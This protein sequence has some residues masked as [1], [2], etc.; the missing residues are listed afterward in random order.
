VFT[1]RVCQPF[2]SYFVQ[3]ASCIHRALK[4][5]GTWRQSKLAFYGDAFAA[6]A[7]AEGF[8]AAFNHIER[9]ASE[10]KSPGVNT[11]VARN[12]YRSGLVAGLKEGVG[13]KP[14]HTRAPVASPAQAAPLALDAVSSGPGRLR[15]RRGR[16]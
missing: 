5:R 13:N 9:L 7:A 1:K 4:V 16:G 2:A 6:E 8:V 3:V 15:R 11:T 12:S 14:A 10:H